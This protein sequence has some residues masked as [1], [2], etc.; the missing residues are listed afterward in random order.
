MITN[1][2][3]IED[4]VMVCRV[5]GK[6]RSGKAVFDESCLEFVCK[7]EACTCFNP[8]TNVIEYFSA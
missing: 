6:D 1:Y 7:N 2:S 3:E 4:Y 8:K 5:L